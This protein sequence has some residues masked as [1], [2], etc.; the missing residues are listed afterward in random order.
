MAT[1]SIV[2]FHVE[3]LTKYGFKANG[4]FVNYSKNFKDQAKVVP[5]VDIEAEVYTADSGKQYVN[6]L[7]ATT[8][9]VVVATSGTEAPAPTAPAKSFTPRFQKKAANASE[10]MSKADWAAKDR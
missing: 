6:K 4:E 9:G 2:K 3:A 1:T 8:I 7:L 10:S 5:G